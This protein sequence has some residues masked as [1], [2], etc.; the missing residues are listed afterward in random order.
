MLVLHLTDRSA[1][2]TWHRA[3][4][5]ITVG[6]GSLTPFPHPALEMRCA[7]TA[8]ELLVVVRERCPTAQPRASEPPGNDQDGLIAPETAELLEALDAEAEAWPLQAVRVRISRNGGHTGVTLRAGRWGT[9]PLFL[10]AS[11]RELWAHW[12]PSAL[13]PR[14]SDHAL[15]RERV[16]LYLATFSTPYSRRTMLRDLH[17]LTERATARWNGASAGCS[18]SI[19][20][21][22]AIRRMRPRLLKPDADVEAA[23]LDIIA[24]ST[25]RWLGSG[26]RGWSELSGGLDSA[27]VSHA[28]AR[29]AANGWTTCG[30]LLPGGHRQ[31]QIARRREL[32]SRFGCADHA[33]ELANALPFARGGKRAAR[34]AVVLPWE[35]TYYEAAEAM[36]QHVAALGGNLVMTGFGG[37]ELCAMRRD[38][39]GPETSAAND[40]EEALPDFLTAEARRAVIESAGRLDP[41]P[42]GDV[43]ASAVEAAA[44]SSAMY[45][46]QGVWPVHP[47]CTPELV[48]F[49]AALPREWRADRAIARRALARVGCSPSI[50]HGMVDNFVPAL[51]LSLRTAAR[52]FME[53]LFHDCHVADAGY[54]EG[55]ALR[56]AFAAWADRSDDAD[57]AVPFYAVATIELS[58]R[59]L[60]RA[61]LPAELVV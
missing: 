14:L 50:T 61:P 6:D 39:V 58:L 8:D 4:S 9:A 47:L 41:A 49:C 17:L 16:A 53:A 35:E 37:D 57:G 7:A 45:L 1:Q 43:S 25:A 27:L 56:R 52:P 22:A 59:S 48:R 20:Y 46:R 42:A 30:L 55:H 31:D 12:D 26:I 28:A 3:K 19:D 11:P 54:V 13:L 15:D 2:G 60:D 5:G 29:S 40:A 32:V 24:A 33:V 34:G 38:E 51:A 23:F 21:P 44:F 18:L 36:L 10:T